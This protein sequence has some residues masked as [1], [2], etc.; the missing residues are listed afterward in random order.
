MLWDEGRGEIKLRTCGRL[1]YLPKLG[2][3]QTLSEAIKTHCYPY[4]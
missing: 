1:I 2:D 4:V 3:L